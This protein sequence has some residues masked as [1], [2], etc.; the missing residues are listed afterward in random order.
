M[1]SPKEITGRSHGT[2]NSVVLVTTGALD[3]ALRLLVYASLLQGDSYPSNWFAM[4]LG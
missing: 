1:I 4:D 3:P 2:L